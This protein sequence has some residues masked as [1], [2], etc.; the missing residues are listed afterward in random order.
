MLI[1]N[2]KALMVR[3]SAIDGKRLTYKLMEK[4]C[5]IR[6]LTLSRIASNQSYNISR[7]DIE[8]LLLYFDCQP[9]DLFTLIRKKKKK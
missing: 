5:G 9:S 6:A 8:K 1:I 2:L 3:K 4:D 7:E